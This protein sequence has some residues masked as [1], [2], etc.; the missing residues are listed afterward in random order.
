[1]GPTDRL[2]SNLPS[3]CEVEAVLWNDGQSEE[4][5]PCYRCSWDEFVEAMVKQPFS[6]MQ[7]KNVQVV[8]EKWWVDWFECDDSY[9]NEWMVHYLPDTTSAPHRIPRT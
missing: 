2:K 9:Y 6:Y 3:V 1:M 4:S 8:A 5:S 7:F